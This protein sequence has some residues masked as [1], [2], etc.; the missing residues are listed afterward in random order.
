MS[1]V[2]LSPDKIEA[3]ALWAFCL[4]LYARS[5]VEAACLNLQDEHGFD[6]MIVLFCIYAGHKGQKLSAK[7]LEQAAEIGREWGRNI[8]GPLRL[9][10]RRLK[11]NI[12]AAVDPHDAYRLRTRL[13]AL[14]QDAERIQHEQLFKL[15]AGSAP[16][17]QAAAR[18]NLVSYA[19]KLGV[20]P[21][22]EFDLLL[23][24]A[25]PRG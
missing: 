9:V 21:P 23:K 2:E 17:S 13:Q 15:I 19:G 1:R 22:E 8:V 3:E 18:A 5:E 10:R 12:P 6:V 14:E 25:F 24:A 11:N 16:P 7:T 4:A 20:S